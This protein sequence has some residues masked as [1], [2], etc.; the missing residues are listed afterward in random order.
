MLVTEKTKERLAVRRFHRTMKSKG[1]RPVDGFGCPVIWEMDRGALKDHKIDDVVI[2][3]SGQS[4][5]V[6]T[7]PFALGEKE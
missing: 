1:Y 3:I 5:W 6:K 7:T 2:D 4:L